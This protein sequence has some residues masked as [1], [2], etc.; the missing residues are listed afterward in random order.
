MGSIRGRGIDQEGDEDWVYKRVKE[1][2]ES[3]IAIFL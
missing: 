2:K 1:L 3:Y